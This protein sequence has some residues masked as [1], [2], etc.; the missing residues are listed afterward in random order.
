MEYIFP[1]LI[2][3]PQYLLKKWQTTGYFP[4]FTVSHYT[5]KNFR[6]QRENQVTA[7]K[8]LDREKGLWWEVRRIYLLDIFWLYLYLKDLGFH[9]AL[10]KNSRP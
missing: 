6:L 7:K 4:H 9:K 2:N 10:A 3:T 1:V 5:R 8:D